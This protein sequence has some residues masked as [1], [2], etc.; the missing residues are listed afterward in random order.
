MKR[1]LDTVSALPNTGFI[2]LAEPRGDEGV[3]RFGEIPRMTF[4]FAP[5]APSR[6]GQSSKPGDITT[7]ER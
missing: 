1:E 7:E 6:Y 2:R 3:R 4:R 5:G